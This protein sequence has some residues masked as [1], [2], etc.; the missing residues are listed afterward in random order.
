MPAFDWHALLGLGA[1]LMAAGGLAG[2][3]G[4][5]IGAGGGLIL[6]PVLYHA[7]TALG[8]DA[9]IRMHLVVGTALATVVPTSLLGMRSHWLRGNVDTAIV[10]RLALPVL[11][12]AVLAGA[13]VGKIHSAGLALVF[14]TVA[15]LVSLNMASRKSL[16]LR[17]GLPG[18]CATGLIGASIG[19]LSTLVGIG[20]ATLTVPLLHAFR[21]PMPVAIGTAS[22]LGSMIGLPGAIAFMGSGW[23]DARTPPG[24]IGY[25]NVLAAAIIFPASAAAISVGA[26]FT[27]RVNERVLRTMFALLMAATAV[28]ML[29]SLP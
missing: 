19:S 20:G 12:G 23:G 26:R 5:M 3:L 25:V 21:T 8:V 14:A 15:A 13:M 29:S 10:K 1:L 4:G 24:S 11:L 28:R 27:R 22:V 17:Q 16:S 9:D 6:V 2:F 7:F 18:P